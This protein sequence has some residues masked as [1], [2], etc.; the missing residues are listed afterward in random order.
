MVPR[1]VEVAASLPKTPTEKVRKVELRAQ[2][3]TP[4]TWDRE[5][6]GRHSIEDGRHG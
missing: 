3:I 5:A 6:A 4:T 1:Y 2:G